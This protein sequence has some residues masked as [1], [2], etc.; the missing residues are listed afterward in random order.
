MKKLILIALAA[1][2]TFAAKSQLDATKWK[3]TLQINDAPTDVRLEFRKDTAEATF[4]E[5][6]MNLETA[7]YTVKDSV[8]TYQKINGQSSCDDGIGKYKFVLQNDQFTLTLLD[9]NCADRSGVLDKSVWK[10]EK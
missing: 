1:A 3:A 7:L 6:G 2:V 8:F 5:N 10:R 4:A 9:D